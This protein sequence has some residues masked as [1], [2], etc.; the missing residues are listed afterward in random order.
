MLFLESKL[1]YKFVRAIS[2]VNGM[3]P[4]RPSEI[5]TPETIDIILDRS[6]TIYCQ[7]SRRRQAIDLGVNVEKEMKF[8]AYVAKHTKK[9]T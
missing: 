8:S 4:I 2:L 1:E 6:I 3:P 7:L 9:L 5:E